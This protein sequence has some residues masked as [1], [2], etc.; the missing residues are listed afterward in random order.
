MTADAAGAELKLASSA[1]PFASAEVSLLTGPKRGQAVIAADGW[2]KQ[3]SAAAG[4][5]SVLRVKI[6]VRSTS[7]S[8]KVVGDGPVTV[9]GWSLVAKS[10]WCPLHQSRHPWCVG[11]HRAPFRP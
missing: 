8:I 4:T 1:G 7:L 5:Q 10:S 6:P 3:V 2:R 11:I 9:L